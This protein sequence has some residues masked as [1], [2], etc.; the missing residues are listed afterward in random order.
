MKRMEFKIA[1]LPAKPA[2]SAHIDRIYQQERLAGR[3]TWAQLTVGLG[4]VELVFWHPAE[5]QAYCEVFALHPFPTSRSL[6]LRDADETRLNRHWLSRLPKAAK[7]PKFRAR[8]L[9]YVSSEPEEL[10]TFRHFYGL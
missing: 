3:T 1:A 2:G 4:D 5:L 7:A 10:K 8:F 6:V 9:E